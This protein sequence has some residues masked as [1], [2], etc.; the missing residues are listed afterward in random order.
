MQT[1]TPERLINFD[2][3]MMDHF[4]KALDVS[5][6]E[7]SEIMLQ[8]KAKGNPPGDGFFKATRIMLSAFTNKNPSNTWQLEVKYNSEL[9][10]W[11]FPSERIS[12]NAEEGHWVRSSPHQF[13]HSYHPF[14]VQESLTLPVYDID[15]WRHGETPSEHEIMNLLAQTEDR[16][17]GVLDSMPSWRLYSTAK[18]FRV[19]LPEGNVNPFCNPQVKEVGKT[20]GADERY[21]DMCMAV[22][23]WAARIGPKKDRFAGPY[24]LECPEKNPVSVTKLLA[25]RGGC[26]MP[27]W[28]QMHDR[29]SGAHFDRSLV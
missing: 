9:R 8:R 12:I 2:P 22:G 4:A 14:M 20:F 27:R 18:G 11:R 24:D 28:L 1:L 19:I 21:L 3:I 15:A 23:T 25:S 16:L 10:R 17:R 7:L 29:A 26:R 6:Q 5:A 13:I